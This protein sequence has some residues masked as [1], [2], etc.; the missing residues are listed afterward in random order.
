MVALLPD[1]AR[2]AD[3][4]C[5]LRLGAPTT[6]TGTL[7]TDENVPSDTSMLIV[8]LTTANGV[9]KEMVHTAVFAPLPSSFWVAVPLTRASCATRID[10]LNIYR[11]QSHTTRILESNKITTT[12]R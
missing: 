4:N 3:E 1:A 6:L 12:H 2:G 11:R 7:V 9:V 5:M 8:A 10:Y